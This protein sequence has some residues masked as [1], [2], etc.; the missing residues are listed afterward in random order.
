MRSCALLR[1]ERANE[2][3]GGC[4]TPQL[5]PSPHPSLAPAL[6][7]ESA[8]KDTELLRDELKATIHSMER[9]VDGMRRTSEAERKKQEELM[10]ERDVLNKLKTQAEVRGG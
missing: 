3:R 2:V 4:L 10:R 5:P 8:K 7:V 6:Q 9:E 1:C